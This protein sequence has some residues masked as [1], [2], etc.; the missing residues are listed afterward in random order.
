[1]VSL[2]VIVTVSPIFRFSAE[3]DNTKLLLITIVQEGVVGVGVRVGISVSGF[4]YPISV[5]VAVSGFGY[6]ISVGV[7][8]D[9]RV[10]V[11]VIDGMIVLVGV[12]VI[13]GVAVGVLVLPLVML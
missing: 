1:M 12:R 9:V 5:G 3:A 10:G 7:G 2:A 13:V 11:Y 4:G 8:V 6:P